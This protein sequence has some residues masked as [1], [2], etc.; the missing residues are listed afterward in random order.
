M[1]V[2][3]S[4]KAAPAE[5]WRA[6]TD[7]VVVK[8]WFGNLSSDLLPRAEAR[9][10]FGDGDFFSIEGVQVDPPY[11]LKYVWRFLGIG[12]P[13]SITWRITPREP[14][15]VV[16]VTDS[17]PER[18]SEWARELET[19]WLDFTRRLETFLRTGRPARY[20]WSRVFKGNIDLA[21]P[22]E[23]M[24]G[25]LFAPGAQKEWLPLNG[26]DLQAGRESTLGDDLTPNRFRVSNVVWEA[27]RSVS[28]RLT[29]EEW[30]NRTKCYLELSPCRSGSRLSVSHTGWDAI[31]LSAEDQL[32]QR[33]RFSAHWI[34]ALQSASQIAEGA[35]KRNV[36]DDF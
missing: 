16:T 36:S 2:T 10:D 13:D 29:C 25:A 7:R 12:P 17:E 21:R 15:C 4:V 5:I 26:A 14:G 24:W 3:V 35:C 6:L 18:S 23:D 31:S 33:K 20:D 1:S 27:P 34:K 28:F 9:L 11:E 32:R 30:L 19:G 8:Q 22:A